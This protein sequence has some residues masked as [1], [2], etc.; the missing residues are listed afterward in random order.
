MRQKS[1]IVQAICE[2]D[3][4]RRFRGRTAP[5]CQTNFEF[6]RQF[7]QTY[8][9]L[10][11]GKVSAAFFERTNLGKTNSFSETLQRLFFKKHDVFFAQQQAQFVFHACASAYTAL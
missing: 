2:N 11:D 8:C 4:T 6:L 9:F 7:T 5:P 3:I 1:R 10:S